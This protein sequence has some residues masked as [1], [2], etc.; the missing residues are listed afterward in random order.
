MRR[1][2]RFRLGW[3]LV[4]SPKYADPKVSIADELKSRAQKP[5]PLWH[6]RLAKPMKE[7]G[8]YSVLFAYKG[9]VFANAVAWV[10]RDVREEMKRSGFPFAFR[11]AAVGFP[12]RP[13]SLLQ[14][15]LGRRARRHHSLIRLDE[16]TLKRYYELGS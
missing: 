7:G 5:N 2:D 15:N 1:T 10:T 8:P 11:L 6:W 14:L 3:I 4:H 12:R 13:V 16:Q 9:K